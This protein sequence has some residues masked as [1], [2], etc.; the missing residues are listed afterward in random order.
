[1]DG[2][3][4]MKGLPK[5]HANEHK[6]AKRNWEN[7]FQKWSDKESQDGYTDYGKCGYGSMCDYCEDIGNGRPCVRALN[8]MLREKEI[9]INYYVR[10]FEAIWRGVDYELNIRRD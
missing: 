5:G 1:M 8:Q 2:Q 9:A 6:R 7:A 4:K 10:D 3:L